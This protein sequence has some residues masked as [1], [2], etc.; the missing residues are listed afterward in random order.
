METTIVR[1]PLD[2]HYLLYIDVL[3][4]EELA[5][6]SPARVDDLF[7]IIASLN[8]HDHPTFSAIVFSD[9][10]LVHN[11]VKPADDDDRRYI[12][13]YQCEFYQDLI[14]RLIGRG[15]WLRG[16][17]TYGP[18]RHYEL[19]GTPYFYGPALNKAYHADKSLNLTGLVMDDHCHRYSQIFKSQPLGEGWNYVFVT[20]GLDE[21]EEL[22]EGTIPVP[23][24]VLEELG[25]NLGPE[26]ELLAGSLRMSKTHPDSRV[27]EKHVETLRLYRSR[28]PKTFTTL[29]PLAF[30]MEAVSKRFDWGRVRELLREDY[31]GAAEKRPPTPGGARRRRAENKSRPDGG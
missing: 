25:W 21:F 12:V 20:Q 18:F 9:T 8:V 29:E 6:S 13:M 11:V 22:C 15:V 30:R 16:V 14:H 10:I 17:L 26:L 28:Y 19:N 3:G 2:D 4:F 31:S 1:S 23:W 5:D 27:R 7:E 24:I